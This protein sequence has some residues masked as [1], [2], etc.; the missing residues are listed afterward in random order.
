[1]SS[2]LGITDTTT[3]SPG[4]GKLHGE[5]DEEAEFVCPFEEE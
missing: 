4:T 3:P 5:P 1:V 2:T